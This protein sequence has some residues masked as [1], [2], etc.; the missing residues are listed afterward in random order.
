MFISSTSSVSESSI[1]AFVIVRH[2]YKLIAIYKMNYP[3]NIVNF[4]GHL[5]GRGAYQRGALI[6]EGRLLES[7][8]SLDRL[9][10]V[11]LQ[12]LLSYFTQIVKLIYRRKR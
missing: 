11:L 4:K 1:V 7:R 12:S 3:T 8:R 9:R 5:L 10:Y 2:A 6:R